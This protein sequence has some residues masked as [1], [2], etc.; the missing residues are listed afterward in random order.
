MK[1]FYRLLRSYGVALL[2]CLFLSA[3]LCV[4]EEAEGVKGMAEEEFTPTK[5]VLNVKFVEFD[6]PKDVTV[7]SLEKALKDAEGVQV[8]LQK[9]DKAFPNGGGSV[10]AAEVKAVHDGTAIYF[11]V[12]WDDATKNAQAIATQEFRDGVALM[13]PLGKVVVSTDEKFSPRMGDR[14][15]PVNLWHWKADWEADMVASGGI[16]ECPV[17]YPNMHDD[18]STNPHSVNYHKGLMQSAA[19][20]AGGVSAHNLLSMPN[21]GRTVEDL[22]AEGFGTLTSQDHQDVNACSKYENSKWTVI[23]YRLLNSNDPLDV[24]FVPGESTYFNMAVWNG[25]KEDRNGQKNISTQWHPLAL[26]RIAWQ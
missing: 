23:F 16:E 6:C 9:Q 21:R 10:N 8:K 2:G 25:D 7:C 17:R 13:F 19:V 20:L 1:K 22:N 26:E 11:Q 15:K 4:A 3:T 18:F 14:Q 5:E 24:Q 12:S